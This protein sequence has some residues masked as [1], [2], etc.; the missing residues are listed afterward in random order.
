MKAKLKEVSNE[1]RYRML[2]SIPEQ[3][4]WLK[5][6]VTGYFAYHS[7]PTNS[8]ALVTFRDQI[9]ALARGPASPESKE[10]INLDPNEEAGVT[11]SQGR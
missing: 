9:I 10:R 7:V 11:G 5:Q 2:R 4:T 1:L 6:V 3:G 8:A